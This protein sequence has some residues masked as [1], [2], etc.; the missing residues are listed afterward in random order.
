MIAAFNELLSC[1]VTGGFTALFILG[2]VKL[3]W[4]PM[5]IML[6]EEDLQSAVEVEEDEEDIYK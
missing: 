6:T 1:I 3:G 2:M 4:L 5:M